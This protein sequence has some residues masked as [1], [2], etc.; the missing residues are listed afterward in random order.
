M[1]NIAMSI[2]HQIANGFF[3]DECEWSVSCHSCL[4]CTKASVLHPKSKLQSSLHGRD[5]VEQ[6]DIVSLGLHW[7]Q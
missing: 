3:G 5:W 4:L 2:D 7:K 1:I 6:S